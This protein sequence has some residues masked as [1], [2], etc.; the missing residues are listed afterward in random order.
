MIIIEGPD[1]AGKSTLVD[2]IRHHSKLGL[3]KTFYPKQNQLSYYIHTP[4]QYAN[5]YLERYYI[6]ELVYPEFKPGRA[7]MKPWHQYLIEAGL[8]PFAPVILYVR[9]SRDTI[10]ENM[11]RRGDDYVSLDEVD[12]M[13]DTYDRKI[14]NSY[15]PNF[16]FDYKEI[17]SYP[18]TQDFLD[19]LENHHLFLQSEASRY[20]KFL[21]SGDWNA[22]SPIMFIGD[23]PSKQSIGNGFIRAFSSPTGSSEFLHE[24]LYKAGC[25][26]DH[27]MPYFTNWNKCEDNDRLNAKMLEEELKLVNPRAIVCLGE[28]IRKKVGEGETIHHPSYIKRFKSKDYEFYIDDIKRILNNHK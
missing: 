17:K 1:N 16:K 4:A 28:E 27:L 14:E 21:S 2:F 11:K 8:M 9:P 24:C 26:P 23:M 3:I 18:E 25:Y 10:I 6:S 7:K 22:P 5:F 19:F 13:L 12:L 15:V 20:Q